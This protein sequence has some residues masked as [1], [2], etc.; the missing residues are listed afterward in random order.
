VSVNSSSLPP[1]RQWAGACE[2]LGV[3]GEQLGGKLRSEF[4]F[5]TRGGVW[6]CTPASPSLPLLSSLLGPQ[7][8][9]RGKT[10]LDSLCSSN[11]QGQLLCVFPGGS[12]PFYPHPAL[13]TTTTTAIMPAL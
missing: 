2:E 3:R 13:T 5:S 1:S 9:G 4:E 8:S 6:V 10:N 12:G 11:K 7:I